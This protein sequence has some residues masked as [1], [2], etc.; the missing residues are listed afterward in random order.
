M[1]PVMQEYRS[2]FVPAYHGARVK[3]EAL[4]SCSAYRISRGVHRTHPGMPCRLRAADAEMTA[5]GI[6]VCFNIDPHAGLM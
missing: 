5:D 4:N 2:E 1:A 3:V 6:V